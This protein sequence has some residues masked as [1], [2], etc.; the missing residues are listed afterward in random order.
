MTAVSIHAFGKLTRKRQF[1]KFL[2]KFLIQSINFYHHN[3]ENWPT[4]VL[5]D[6]QRA[7]CIKLLDILEKSH[8]NIKIFITLFAVK[9]QKFYNNFMQ[10]SFKID[11]GYVAQ[12]LILSLRVKTN[13]C[14]RMKSDKACS[15]GLRDCWRSWS[16]IWTNYSWSVISR[17]K[18]YFRYV[19]RGYYRRRPDW[20]S[21]FFSWAFCIFDW[22]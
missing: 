20:S 18:I 1:L 5:I 15:R 11:W 3:F 10:N 19:L 4:N 12:N 9:D 13:D 8:T 2:K 16:S 7:F 21:C 22:Q 6:Y 17:E 14:T